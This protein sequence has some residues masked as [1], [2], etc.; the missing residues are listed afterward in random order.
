MDHRFIIIFRQVY[1]QQGLCYR[2]P[3]SSIGI[4][5]IVNDIFRGERTEP[6]YKDKKKI[7]KSEAQNFINK[8][9]SGQH[10]Q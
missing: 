5:D 10:L 8:C 1:K 2:Q 9:F 7:K 6:L 4:T 3:T